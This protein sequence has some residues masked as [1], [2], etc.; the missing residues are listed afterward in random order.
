MLRP[1]DIFIRARRLKNEVCHKLTTR[2]PVQLRIVPDLSYRNFIPAC[3][4][5]KSHL[6]DK[7]SSNALTLCNIKVKNYGRQRQKKSSVDDEAGS[8]EKITWI[9]KAPLAAEATALS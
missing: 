4:K 7:K 1:S 9:I 6:A 5:S 3:K 8:N 2:F